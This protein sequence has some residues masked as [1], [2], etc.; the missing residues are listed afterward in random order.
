[1]KRSKKANEKEKVKRELGGKIDFFAMG[2][3]K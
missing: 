2:G 1:V 3:M